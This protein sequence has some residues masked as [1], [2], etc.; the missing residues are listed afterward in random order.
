MAQQYP[1]QSP[2]RQYPPQEETF[3]SPPLRK[4]PGLTTLAFVLILLLAVGVILNANVLKI[5]P[6]NVQVKG[7]GSFSRE[8]VIALAGLDQPVS[9][10]AVSGEKVAKGVESNRYLMFLSMEKIFPNQVILTVRERVPVARVQEMSADYYLDAEGMV[11]ERGSVSAQVQDSVVMVTGL[12]PKE[13]RLGQIMTTATADH[14]TAYL[15]LFSELLQQN[16]LSQVSELNLSDPANLYLMTR[17]GYF[18]RLGDVTDMRAKI[19]TVRAVVAKLREMGETEGI[20]EAGVPG[21]AIYSPP[22]KKQ[23]KNRDGGQ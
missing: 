21:E 14:K 22:G 15:T 12:K 23:E 4:H 18:V 17:D 7:G 2:P 19:G 20:L 5:D 16:W 9:Y 10:F 13:L 8:T 1:Q 3:S 6:A 11:L